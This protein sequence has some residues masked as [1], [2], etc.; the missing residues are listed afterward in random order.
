M[1]HI[2][3]MKENALMQRSGIDGGDDKYNRLNYTV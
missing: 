3:R 1:R 2:I